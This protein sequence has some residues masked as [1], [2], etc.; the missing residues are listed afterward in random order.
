MASAE[1]ASNKKKSVKKEDSNSTSSDRLALLKSRLSVA[2]AWA[3]KPHKAMKTWIEEYEIKDFS[4]TEEVR[5]KVRIG[6]IFRKAEGELPAI[7]DDQPELFIKGRSAATKALNPLFDGLYDYLWDIEGFEEIIDDIGLYFGVVGMGFLDSPW[8][9]KTK[10]VPQM[11]Q[12]PVLDPSTQ[13]P[14]IDPMT[15]QTQM[16]EVEKVFEVPE[17]DNPVAKA[18]DPFKIFFSPETKFNTILDYEHCPYLFLPE[19]WT[20]ERVKAQFGV[21][22]QTEERLHTDESEADE[23][24]E[25][26]FESS[27]NKDDL[28]RVTVYR[29]YGCLPEDMAQGL[30][31]KDG[32]PST[33]EYDKEYEIYFTTEK[34]LSAKECPYPTK[35]VFP[36]GNYGMANKF[37][38]F[39][40]TKHLM[41]L[42]QELQQYRS[43]IL[44][45][46]RKMANPK[47]MI[48]EDSNVDKEL[49]NDPRVGVPVVYH[50]TP[51]AYLSP[52]NLGREVEVGVQMARTDLEKT[53]PSFDLNG[54]GGESQVRSPRGIQVYAEASDRAVRRKRKKFARFIRHVFIFQ[55][56]QLGLF[57]KPD[58]MKKVE[59]DGKDETMT[60]EVLQILQDPNILNKLDIE[61]ES[62]SVN[63]VQMKQDAL[64]FF[65]IA[66]KYPNVFNLME[67]AKDLVQ[68]AFGKRDADRY[69]VSQQQVEQETIQKFIQT[70]AQ[71][72]PELAAT[73]GQY[74]QQPNFMA[75]MDKQQQG[76]QGQNPA[77]QSG[78]DFQPTQQTND[79]GMA[80]MPELGGA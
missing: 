55:F 8:V 70:L 9:T 25:D 52:A 24:I 10:K 37:W 43:Q 61:I 79:S 29:Y 64:D 2:K 67:C 48:E 14:L 63:K 58:D 76:A 80:A 50:G 21:D 66:A 65:D 42:V 49:F 60:A 5:D 11:V 78:G 1:I 7:F 15:G 39:G 13:Q 62:L 44:K 45:H 51:P 22:V 27:T 69:L 6:Y 32:N 47:P 28:K 3:K 19:T 12:E 4:D 59:I 20:K 72:N 35:P 40:D 16:Q 36:I 17:I 18:I 75:L 57:W 71:A 26:E 34:E 31:D 68:N 23:Q 74:V 54:G 38:K 73:V 41:P 77:T 46:T 30:T 33:W 53:G 56:Q